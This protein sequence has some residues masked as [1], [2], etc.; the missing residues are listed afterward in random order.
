VIRDPRTDPQVGDVIR[1]SGVITLRV[2]KRDGDTVGWQRLKYGAWTDDNGWSLRG[3][4][5]VI[6]KA[7]E[8]VE[9]A[10]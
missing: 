6:A 5:E 4:Q 1:Q 3:W 10:Q 8:V 7:A 9:V 2:S